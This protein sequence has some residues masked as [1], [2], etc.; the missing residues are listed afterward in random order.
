[1]EPGCGDGVCCGVF[2]LVFVGFLHQSLIPQP[3]TAPGTIRGGGVS[4]L[5]LS[6]HMAKASSYK[7]S[8]AGSPSGSTLS[9]NSCVALVE[10]RNAGRAKSAALLMPRPPM[11]VGREAWVQI[12][13]SSLML[14]ISSVA[15]LTLLSKSSWSSLALYNADVRSGAPSR[16]AVLFVIGWMLGATALN[17]DSTSSEAVD[18]LL[19]VRSSHFSV[20]NSRSNCG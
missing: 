9:T 12:G 19:E 6:F 17:L 14:Q 13:S 7:G 18:S 20:F 16:V 11:D 4:P 1:M 5:E 2:L 15:S 8:S 10:T 3:L